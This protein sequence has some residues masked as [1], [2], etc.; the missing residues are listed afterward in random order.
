MLEALDVSPLSLVSY[1]CQQFR[2]Q[3]IKKFHMFL[4]YH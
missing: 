3:I 4:E 1:S 2:M